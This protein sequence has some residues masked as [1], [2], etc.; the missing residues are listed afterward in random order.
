M[1]GIYEGPNS[2]E[3]FQPRRWSIHV[4]A[5]L[6]APTKS[7]LEHELKEIPGVTRLMLAVFAKHGIKSIEDLAGCATDDLAGWRELRR[8]QTIQHRGILDGF[9]LSRQNCDAMIL[10]ARVKAGWISPEL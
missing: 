2:M 6:S 5:N 7:V 1:T 4:Q 3:G 10:S 9:G 8:T